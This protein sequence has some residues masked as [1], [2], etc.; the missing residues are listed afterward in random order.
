MIKIFKLKNID[1]NQCV[2]SKEEKDGTELIREAFDL[3]SGAKQEEK[4]EPESEPAVEE[5]EP[6]EEVLKESVSEAQVEPVP[7]IAAEDKPSPTTI[8]T[9]GLPETAAR[10]LR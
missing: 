7:E 8:W 10:I 9:R 6:V 2:F 1:S 5:I 3:L 4:T